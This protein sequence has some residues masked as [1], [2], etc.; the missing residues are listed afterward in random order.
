MSHHI[1]Q[2]VKVRDVR[3]NEVLM[4]GG[5]K[6]VD[7]LNSQYISTG[8]HVHLLRK[9]PCTYHPD[10]YIIIDLLVNKNLFISFCKVAKIVAF[11]NFVLSAKILISFHLLQKSTS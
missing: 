3:N 9:S 8:I 11:V 5:S 4:T 7:S 2:T 10:I 1:L 6:W